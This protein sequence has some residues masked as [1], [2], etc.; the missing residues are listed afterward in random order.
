MA[1]H[2]HLTRAPLREA[3]IDLQFEPRVS[4]DAIDRF[5]GA[6]S[7]SFGRKADLWEA[8][9]GLNTDVG[10]A[11]THSTHTI[12]GRRLESLDA[13]YVLQC[14][15]SGFTLSR[16]SPY[17]EWIDLRMEAKRLWERFLE[18]VGEVVIRRV[19][20]RYINEIRL[21]LPLGDFSEYL[22]CPPQ[23]PGPLPQA[24]TGF[25]SRVI[26]PDDSMNCVS[27]V[28]Q[29]FEGSP[30]QDPTGMFLTIILDIDVFRMTA[31]VRSQGEELWQA[32]DVLRDQKNRMF[33]EHITEKAARIYE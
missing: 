12:A 31:L 15:L 13:P 27:V 28:T 26:I 9:F 23:V 29:A 6:I 18:H 10:G 19:A 32:L 33:F 5:V 7:G 25:L 2:R 30:V 16:L 11:A 1:Q 21:P 8:F 14:R 17:G 22:T 4:L 3:L 20:V 24:V